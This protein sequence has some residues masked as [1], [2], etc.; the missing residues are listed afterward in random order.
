MLSPS[1]K[2]RLDIALKRRRIR[3]WREVDP[4]NGLGCVIIEKPSREI[5]RTDDLGARVFLAAL[6]SRSYARA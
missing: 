2:R 5:L 1:T 6:G 3:Q 4:K